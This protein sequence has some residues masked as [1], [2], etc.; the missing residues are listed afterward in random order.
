MQDQAADQEQEEQR[1][2]EVD[3]PAQRVLPG[4]PASSSTPRICQPTVRATATTM[5]LTPI[6]MCSHLGRCGAGELGAGN[7]HVARVRVG[8]LSRAHRDPDE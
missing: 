6:V 5:R 7:L 2:E 4:V 3:D 8:R 1:A